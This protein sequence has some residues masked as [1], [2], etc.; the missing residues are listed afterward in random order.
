MI[1]TTHAVLIKPTENKNNLRKNH[2]SSTNFQTKH[3]NN[4][5]YQKINRTDYLC[6][7]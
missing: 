6:F 4:I 1:K 2:A 5:K 3:V 7:L